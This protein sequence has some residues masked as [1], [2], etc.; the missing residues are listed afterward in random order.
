V[1]RWRDFDGNLDSIPAD[2]E[3]A[4]RL[5]RDC[6]ECA[7]NGLTSRLRDYG[8]YPARV[9]CYCHRCEAGRWIEKAHRETCPDIR[10]RIIDLAHPDCA[11]IREDRQ[12]LS[13]VERAGATEAKG[14]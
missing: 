3:E 8:P 9:S 2:R 12:T 6:P 13:A 7:G 14:G 10:R 4:A 11:E 5:A 1:R